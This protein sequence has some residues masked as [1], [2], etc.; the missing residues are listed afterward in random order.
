VLNPALPPDPDAVARLREALGAAGYTPDGVQDLLGP[1]AHGALARLETVP[2][3]RAT[4]G[5][6][7]LE[8]L[9]RLF[10]LQRAV[11]AK[12]AAAALPVDDALAGG[13]LAAEGHEVRALVDLRPYDTAGWWLVSD[14]GTGLDGQHRP[15]PAEHVL[16]VGGAS[17]SLANLTVRP[18]VE[19]AL[20]IGTGCGVQALHLTQHAGHVTA[21]DVLPRAVAM[22]RLTAA[23]SD[24]R[25]DLRQG[26]LLAPV[27][28]ERFDLLVSNPPFVVSGGG[29]HAYRV[30]AVGFGWVA[31][32]RTDAAS[33]AVR[34]E[35]WPYAVEQPMGAHVA[36]L[37]QRQDAL[38]AYDDHAL[39]GARL[40]V[41]PDV[42]QE[43]LGAPG[44]EDPEHIV[45]RQQQGMRRA[46][47]VTTAEAGL[48]GACDGTLHVGQVIAALAVL[49]D[50]DASALRRDL[51]PR[52]R[53]FVADGFLLLP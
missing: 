9:S 46:E 41:A 14:H 40:T 35:D 21:T 28:Q 23:L 16:G 43:Q 24:V 3:E 53:S 31:L 7:P 13:V 52:V 37:F 8:T 42:V 26:D 6:S 32:R 51:L 4:R 20:D 19:R 5:G 33:P 15:L 48:V 47:R 17:T 39:L 50:E 49:L 18:T 45:L 10:L 2:A 36:A 1:T 11:P 44:A 27:A 29:G 38:R 30:E 34:I 22:A 12:A 25:L